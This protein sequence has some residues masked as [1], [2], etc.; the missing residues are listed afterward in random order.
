ML[1]LYYIQEWV[2]PRLRHDHH[3]AL[4]V[5]NSMLHNIWVPDTYFENSKSS[6]F[7]SVTVPNKMLRISQN[8]NYCSVIL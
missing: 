3:D 1:K 4:T 7:H 2:D 5:D 8:G 6:N